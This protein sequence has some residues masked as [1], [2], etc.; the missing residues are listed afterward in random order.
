MILPCFRGFS[1][2]VYNGRFFRRLYISRSMVGWRFRFF[3][4]SK[5]IG[6]SIHLRKK[7]GKNKQK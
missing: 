3:S 6:S 1:V 4:F 5:L 2:L 7:R